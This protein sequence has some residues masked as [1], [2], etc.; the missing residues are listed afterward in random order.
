MVIEKLRIALTRFVGAE[1]YSSLLERALVLA[2]AD[3]P[4]LQNVTIGVAGRLEGIEHLVAD[5]GTGEAPTE[6]EAVVAIAAHLLELLV[7]FI[8]E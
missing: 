5:T 7:T 3:M 1:G 4:S 6:G 8:G 2:R